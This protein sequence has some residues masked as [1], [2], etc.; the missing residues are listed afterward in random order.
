MNNITAY[1]NDNWIRKFETKIYRN[2]KIVNTVEMRNK[3]K[4][5]MLNNLYWTVK[6]PIHNG[7]IKEIAVD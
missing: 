1:L 2:S 4:N 3:I 6:I 5:K 7:I